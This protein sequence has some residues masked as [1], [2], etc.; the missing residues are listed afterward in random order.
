M[1][2]RAG[3]ADAAAR[4]CLSGLD[5]RTDN[6]QTARLRIRPIHPPPRQASQRIF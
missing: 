1:A 6:A 4:H 3:T 5:G 2:L